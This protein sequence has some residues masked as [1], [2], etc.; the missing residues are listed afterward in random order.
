VDTILQDDENITMSIVHTPVTSNHQDNDTQP[1][2][3]V[4][5]NAIVARLAKMMNKFTKRISVRN[6]Q[7]DGNN[8]YPLG[9]DNDD[10]T[11]QVDYVN[12]TKLKEDYLHQAPG[13]DQSDGD[14]PTEDYVNIASDKSYLNIFRADFQQQLNKAKRWSHRVSTVFRNSLHG[15]AEGSGSTPP[16]HKHSLQVIEEPESPQ[17]LPTATLQT[18]V[19]LTN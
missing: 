15:A 18:A 9:Y 11:V 14:E 5:G 19:P 6:E 4:Y 17:S 13:G 12:M 10:D 8:S 1:E 2:D 7:I 3:N 16:I